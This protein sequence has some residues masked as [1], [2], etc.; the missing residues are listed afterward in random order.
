VQR[1]FASIF[2]PEAMTDRRKHKLIDYDERMAVLLQ[3]VEGEQHGR[4]FFPTV[5]GIA[6][7]QNL[8]RWSPEIR[9]QDGLLQ[10][11]L[12][13]GTRIRR[14]H[15]FKGTRPIPL[16]HPQ[17]RPEKTVADIRQQAQSL[18]DVVD[19]KANKHTTIPAADIL[20]ADFALLPFVASLDMG[21]YLTPIN[22]NEPPPPDS[23]FVL[24]FD[25]LTKDP[26]FIKLVRTAVMRLEK[27]YNAPVEIEF[28][29]KIIPNGLSPDYQLTILQCRRLRQMD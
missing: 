22:P 15:D 27:H 29:V 23:H 6:Y 28:T 18:I 25:Y 13:L 4:Y 9:R 19:L 3:K 5:S 12:G 26:K 14:S 7:S 11:V 16:S 10:L 2:N 8:A 17:F 24:T 21:D 1:V 20:T